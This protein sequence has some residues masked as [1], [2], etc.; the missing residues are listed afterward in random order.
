VATSR[1]I[2]ME[3]ADVVEPHQQPLGKT[4]LPAL[5]PDAYIEPLY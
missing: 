5:D 4:N 3:S 2:V 1:T